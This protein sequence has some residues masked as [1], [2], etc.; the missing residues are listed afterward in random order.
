M[1]D[2]DIETAT[3]WEELVDAHARWC[4][5][6]NFQDHS[7]HAERVDGLRSPFQVLHWQRGVI[8][9]EDEL[10]QLFST[11]RFR[12]KLNRVGYL[13]FRNW[14]IYAEEGLPHEEVALFLSEE[15]LT[16]AFEDEPI[17]HYSVTYQ[18]DQKNLLTI[19]NP[20]LN[21]SRQRWPQLRLL[22]MDEGGWRIVY[23]VTK[24]PGRKRKPELPIV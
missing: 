3:T 21:P 17:A 8:Y 5:D 24:Q 14:K 12:R 19:D 2:H 20:H 16:V 4:A 15:H 11:T 9:S 18:L 6:F 1:A 22:D 7:A 13:R 23:R 10:R